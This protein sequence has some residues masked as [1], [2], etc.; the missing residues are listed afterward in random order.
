[1][2]GFRGCPYCFL[3]PAPKTRQ[4]Q[5]GET[6][7]GTAGA[8]GIYVASLNYP[9]V[10]VCRLRPLTRFLLRQ[11]ARDRTFIVVRGLRQERVRHSFSSTQRTF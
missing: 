5:Q 9:Y 2:I 1:M 10:P 3:P 8:L 4:K 11:G 6:K 7:L